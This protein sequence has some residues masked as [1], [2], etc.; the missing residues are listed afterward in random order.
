MYCVCACVRLAWC[1]ST[2]EL[3]NRRIYCR[4]NSTPNDASISRK[5]QLWSCITRLDLEARDKKNGDRS[6][7]VAGPRLWNSL[8]TSLRQIT[9]YGQFRRYLK[10]HLFGNWEITAQP[11][12]WFSAL[13]YL[14]TY[15]LRSSDCMLGLV[16]M[17]CEYEGVTGVYT[18]YATPAPV[19]PPS[20]TLPLRECCVK[21]RESYCDYSRDD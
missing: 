10:T 9:S 6:F 1:A 3:I 15:L 17:R 4:P 19:K 5:N 11:D 8:P 20:V 2:N 13:T 18:V 16:F 21:T 7:A 12:L 14:L